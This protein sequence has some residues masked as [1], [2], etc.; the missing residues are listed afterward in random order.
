[1]ALDPRTPVIVGV[2]QILDRPQREGGPEH[3]R[4]PLDLMVD[5]LH[6]AAADV[7]DVAF[8][9]VAPKGRALLD[10]VD[11]VA[12][13]ASF[14]WRAPNPSLLVAE[15]LGL[16]PRDLVLSVTGGTMPQKLLAD[17]AVSIAA[18]DLDVVAIVGSEAMYSRGLTKKDPTLPHTPW[19]RQDRTQT[20]PPLPFGIEQPPLSDFEIARGVSIPVEIYPLFENALRARNGWSLAEHRRRLGNLWASF[21]AVAARNEH[22]WLQ[23][24]LSAEEI[25]TPSSSNR[26]IAEP[27]TKLMVANLPVD[28]GAALIVCSLEAARAVGVDE[29]RLIF[30]HAHAFGDEHFFV[31]DRIDLDRSVALAAAG[32]DVFAA[33]DRSIDDVAHLDLYSCFPVAVEMGADALGLVVDDPARPLTVTG[34]LTFGGGPGNNYVAHSLATMTQRLREHPGD[35]GLVT[36]LSYFASSHSV[37]LYSSTPPATAFCSHNVQSVVDAT[38]R[39][40]VDERLTGPVTIETYTIVHDR[41]G[42]PTRAT[43]AVK[44]AHGVR[45][46]ATLLD[47]TTL[48]S[49]A[50]TDLNGQAGSVLEDGTFVFD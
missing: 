50:E 14:T 37:A 35:L 47:A 41:D 40:D 7:D 23:Q 2:G 17:A 3:R 22:A 4:E 11:R 33:T 5:A 43:L 12:S 8:G 26:F 36:G 16:T 49:V 15:R 27:Y 39:Q 42:V 29:D 24:A 9:A 38:P 46:W 44:N 25:T 18:G 1:M 21:S 19:T 10:R 20:P 34:G 45:S 30:P 31:S 48:V 28:M 32:R 6:A 13:V